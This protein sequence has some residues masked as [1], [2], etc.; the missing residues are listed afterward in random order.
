MGFSDAKH[1]F[2]L[3]SCA[4]ANTESADA[5]AM[6]NERTFK[7]YEQVTFFIFCYVTKNLIS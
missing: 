4:F 3:V 6:L 2:H 1:S 5:Y 7:A